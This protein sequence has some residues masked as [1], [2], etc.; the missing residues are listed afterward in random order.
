MGFESKNKKKDI[1]G[2]GGGANLQKI[3]SKID[4]SLSLGSNNLVLLANIHFSQ[5]LLKISLK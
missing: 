2:G 4:L 1:W 5:V 3:W